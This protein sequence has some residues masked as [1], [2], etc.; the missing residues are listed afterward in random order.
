MLFVGCHGNGNKQR[1][2]FKLLV[3]HARKPAMSGTVCMA[4][5]AKVKIH[6]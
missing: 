6:F 3:L 1:Y 5:S 2:S 4:C